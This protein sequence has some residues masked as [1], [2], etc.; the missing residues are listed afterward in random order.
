MAVRLPELPPASWIRTEDDGPG[1]PRLTWQRPFTWKGYCTQVAIIL[2]GT[3]FL[4]YFMYQV[5]GRDVLRLTGLLQDKGPNWGPGDGPARI[6]L[7][8]VGS[9]G[10][11][12]M[13]L[14]ALG[15]VYKAFRIRQPDRLTLG[16]DRLRYESESEFW[17]RLVAREVPRSGLGK[18]R[19]EQ[20]ERRQRLTAED[21]AEPVEVGRYLRPADREWLAEVLRRWAADPGPAPAAAPTPPRSSTLT[22]EQGP[23]GQLSFRWRPSPPGTEQERWVTLAVLTVTLPLFLMIIGTFIRLFVGMLTT[24]G[25]EGSPWGEWLWRW[26]PLAFVIVCGLSLTWVSA[27]MLRVYWYLVR[28]PRWARL[29]LTSTTLRYVPGRYL[30]KP[31]RGNV[32]R[33]CAEPAR[34]VP[35]AELGEVRLERADGGGRLTVDHGAERFEIGPTLGDAEREWLAERLRGWAGSSQPPGG[36]PAPAGGTPG[37]SP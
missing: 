16:P 35:R 27:A 8:A 26:F 28:G 10:L 19:L 7:I 32:P 12:V 14:V 20:V 18:V 2:G 9:A 3:A 17:P 30:E 36:Q 33:V 24:P 4:C 23:G 15:M 21:G 37:R 11:L 6:L 22:P 13:A 1:P 31:K 25:E 5:M 34:V 29:T